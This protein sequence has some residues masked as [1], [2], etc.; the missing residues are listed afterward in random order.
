MIRTL[1]LFVLFLLRSIANAQVHEISTEF[2]Q[3]QWSLEK[4]YRIEKEIA[5]EYSPSLPDD[6]IWV[7]TGDTCIRY[8]YPFY[9][10]E[11]ANFVIDSGLLVYPGWKF[12]FALLKTDSGKLLAYMNDAILIFRRDTLS[13]SILNCLKV[14]QRDTINPGLM[15]EKYYLVTHFAPDDEE[16][17]DYTPPVK[18]PKKISIKDSSQARELIHSDVIYI[19]VGGKKRAFRLVSVDWDGTT[20]GDRSG[21][22]VMDAPV[23]TLASGDW[24]TGDPFQVIYR[25]NEK[26]MIK[27]KSAGVEKVQ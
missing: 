25:A 11:R 16:A 15:L 24:W 21:F 8:D 22:Y 2:L 27:S 10:I 4:V 23:I 26:K 3:G 20:Y 13:N 9:M 5:Q 18:M 19:R 1:F 12:G 7:F 17:Y 14:L 6:N